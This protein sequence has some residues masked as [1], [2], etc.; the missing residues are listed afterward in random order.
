ML[1]QF[2]TLIFGAIGEVGGV[3][4]IVITTCGYRDGTEIGINLSM[5][6]GIIHMRIVHIELYGFDVIG[7]IPRNSTLNLREYLGLGPAIGI[8]VGTMDKLVHIAL[9]ISCC[10]WITIATT[11]SAAQIYVASIPILLIATTTSMVD[12]VSIIMIV[13]VFKLVKP[14]VNNGLSITTITI[15]LNTNASNPTRIIILS[16]TL[17]I[18]IVISTNATAFN[19]IITFAM[20]A[21]TTTIINTAIIT[22]IGRTRESGKMNEITSNSTGARM[23]PTAMSHSRPITNTLPIT[24]PLCSNN[25]T[26]Y[27]S[28]SNFVSSNRNNFT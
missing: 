16:I 27:H 7:D 8:L 18:G 17:M 23:P 20:A 9:V 11:D 22:I 13:A 25:S 14:T 2:L 26:N 1:L 6:I 5:A 4:K 24:A 3:V 12:D 28:N 15:N 19:T 10:L 21:I